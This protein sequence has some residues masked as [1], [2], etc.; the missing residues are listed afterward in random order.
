MLPGYIL[1]VDDNAG[2]RNVLFTFFTQK[3]YK[4]EVASEGQE[5]IQKIDKNRPMLVLLDLKMPGMNGLEILNKLNS[6]YSNLPVII[7]SAFIELDI[8]NQGIKQGLVK[9]YI[10]KPFDLEKLLQLV[11]NLIKK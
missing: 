4:V 7:I 8:L 10:S 3:G 5:A 1:V 9:H 2:I 6:Q 11:E